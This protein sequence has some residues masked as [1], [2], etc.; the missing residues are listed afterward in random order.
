MIF[1]TLSVTRINNLA[2]FSWT[3]R[4]DT[5]TIVMIMALKNRRKISLRCLRRYPK[6]KRWLLQQLILKS[7]LKSEVHFFS[8][9]VTEWECWKINLGKRLFKTS[10]QHSWLCFYYYFR[11]LIS[12]AI[13]R[14]LKNKQYLRIFVD[15]LYNSSK[16]KVICSK[17]VW[18]IPRTSLNTIKS[19]QC[20]KTNTVLHC[21][22][23]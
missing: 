10:D 9:F 11:T 23:S 15:H 1:E 4:F 17:K 21:K 19:S 8:D 22:I 12:D 14:L 20:Q 6:R 7:L 2:V 5:F 18:C 13:F 16:Q 3:F